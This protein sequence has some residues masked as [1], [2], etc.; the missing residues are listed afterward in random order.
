[1]SNRES[2]SETRTIHPRAL[3]AL[4]EKAC[5]VMLEVARDLLSGAIPADKF[6]QHDYCGS[7]FCI[8][9]H[10]ALRLGHVGYDASVWIDN[11]ERSDPALFD[12]TYGLFSDDSD[13]PNRQ[14]ASHAIER[15]V[16]DGE[17]H[18]WEY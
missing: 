5:I 18:P 9:G 17:D 7:A 10:V 3:A 16:Y 11:A 2:S 6:N 1:M 4:G 15:Y 12:N 8:A 14:N 13:K